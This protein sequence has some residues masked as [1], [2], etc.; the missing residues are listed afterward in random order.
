MAALARATKALL[1]GVVSRAAEP[2]SMSLLRGAPDG[3][4]AL[5]IQAFGLLSH[6]EASSDVIMALYRSNLA[7]R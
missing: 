5:A 7:H 3:H 2:Q 1:L 4:S 6:F